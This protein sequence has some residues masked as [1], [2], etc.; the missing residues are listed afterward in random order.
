MNYPYLGTLIG[1]IYVLKVPGKESD[2]EWALP[3][4]VPERNTAAHATVASKQWEWETGFSDSS[5][6]LQNNRKLD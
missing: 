3:F 6:P 5:K 2:G 4:L 1:C